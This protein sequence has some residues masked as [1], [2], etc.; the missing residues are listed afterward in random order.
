MAF[1][2]EHY[3]H[4][5]YHSHAEAAHETPAAPAPDKATTK[6]KIDAAVPPAAAAAL[7]EPL[8]GNMEDLTAEIKSLRAEIA[9][10]RQGIRV[11]AE[12]PEKKTVAAAAKK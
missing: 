3:F 2:M 10:L 11:A 4:H 12:V 5:K 9:T 8:P 7:S 1:G 6:A